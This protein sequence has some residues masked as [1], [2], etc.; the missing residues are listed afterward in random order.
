MPAMTPM[1]FGPS[2]RR[3]RPPGAAIAARHRPPPRLHHLHAPDATS[4]IESWP[5]PLFCRYRLITDRGSG[6]SPERSPAIPQLQ[7]ASC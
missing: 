5:R 2:I 4:I 7:E 3:P 1:P 6:L